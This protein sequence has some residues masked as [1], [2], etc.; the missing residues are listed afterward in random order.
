MRYAHQTND[1]DILHF[2]PFLE[3][4]IAWMKSSTAFITCSNNEPVV[5]LDTSGE[6]VLYLPD[7]ITS[8]V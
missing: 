4:D 2:N 5:G 6:N 3:E 1:V 8:F 7:L